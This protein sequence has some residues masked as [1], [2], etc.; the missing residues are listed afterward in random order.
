MTVPP[1]D[2][3]VEVHLVLE[4][5]ADGRISAHLRRALP[6]VDYGT[7]ELGDLPLLL[8]AVLEEGGEMG[9]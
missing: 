3:R 1:V 6:P 7:V 5:A 4:R 9:D 8:E 2:E